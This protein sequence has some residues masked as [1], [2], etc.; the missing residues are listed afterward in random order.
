MMKNPSI[1]KKNFR[2]LLLFV[3]SKK[4]VDQQQQNKHTSGESPMENFLAFLLP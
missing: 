2:Y 1:N 4:N 3:K